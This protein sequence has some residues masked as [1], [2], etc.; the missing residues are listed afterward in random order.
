MKEKEEGLKEAGKTKLGPCTDPRNPLTPEDR[1]LEYE[2]LR[3]RGKEAQ[4]P[5]TRDPKKIALIS[6]GVVFLVSALCALIFAKFIGAFVIQLI[7]G[8][9]L[10]DSGIRRK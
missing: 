5:R 1:Q 10:L 4:F 6:L 9:L 3:K 2:F 7:V 8:I